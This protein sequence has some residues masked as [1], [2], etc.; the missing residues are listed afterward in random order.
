MKLEQAYP[1]RA[2]LFARLGIYTIPPE[3]IA[4]W[5]KASCCLPVRPMPLGRRKVIL[6]LS[7]SRRAALPAGGPDGH[8]ILR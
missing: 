1:H 8:E 2:I 4:T 7:A 5:G 6:P 3:R